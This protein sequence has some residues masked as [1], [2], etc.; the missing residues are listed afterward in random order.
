MSSAERAAL[1]VAAGADCV[2]PVEAPP[3]VLPLL[4]G[5]IRGPVNA[6]VFTED[7][8]SP[9]ELGRR[10]ATR[11]TFGPGVQRRAAR[12]VREIAAGLLR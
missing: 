8:P 10:G 2:Y 3:E 1:Y 4:R 9:A 5:G 6:G 12:A 11:V 7:G